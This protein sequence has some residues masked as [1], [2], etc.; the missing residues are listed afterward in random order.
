MALARRSA[1]A[2][3][4]I[5]FSFQVTLGQ[6]AE[7]RELKYSVLVASLNGLAD[8]Q[9]LESQWSSEATPFYVVP[10]SVNRQVYYRVLAGHLATRD[11]AV[12]LMADLVDR[13][14]KET[15]SDWHVRETGLAVRL[16]SY[17]SSDASRDAMG[18]AADEGI[19]AYTVVA[20]SAD[21]VRFDV[22]AGGFESRAEADHLMGL[23]AAGGRANDLTQRV[24]VMP[25]RV[26]AVLAAARAA[27]PAGA[28]LPE[29]EEAVVPDLPVE[30]T[31]PEVPEEAEDSPPDPD[32]AA[33]AAQEAGP[34]GTL[35]GALPPRPLP[36]RPGQQVAKEGFYLS[37]GAMGGAS[38]AVDAVHGYGG[39]FLHPH[40]NRVGVLVTGMAGR[41]SG[42]ESLSGM[43]ALSFL[44]GQTGNVGLWVMGGYGYYKE[45]GALDLS[46]NLALPAAGGMLTYDLGNAQ[47]IGAF[48]GMFGTF[49]EDLL[50]IDLRVY[51][52]SLGVGLLVGGPGGMGS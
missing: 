25:A 41:G 33:D 51:R 50:S 23:L 34:E 48:T 32:E 9:E 40:M 14:I 36:A 12:A 47:L 27:D 39:L 21:G 11:A 19:P 29:A 2:L 6:A 22:Y 17:E 28:A 15:A 45:T 38:P 24:G 13:G 52:G 35:S 8:A 44:L 10:V 18:Q 30:E 37:V 31:V 49:E 1:L 7:Q 16:G 46:R 4:G 42:Y 3:V 26:G 43:G 5:L 20:E